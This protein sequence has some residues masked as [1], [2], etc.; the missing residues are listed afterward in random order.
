MERALLLL[1]VHILVA[2]LLIRRSRPNDA[3]AVLYRFQRLAAYQLL[4]G[5]DVEWDT[6][7]PPPPQVDPNTEVADLLHSLQL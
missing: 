2:E 3:D 5:D 1:A 4:W 6:V 7:V